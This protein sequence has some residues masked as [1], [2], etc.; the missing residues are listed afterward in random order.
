MKM[1][2][3]EL[4][5]SIQL[6]IAM[7]IDISIPHTFY[8]NSFTYHTETYTTTPR[9]NTNGQSSLFHLYLLISSPVLSIPWAFGGSRVDIFWCWAAHPVA[10][11]CAGGGQGWPWKGGWHAGRQENCREELRIPRDFHRR[12]CSVK[13]LGHHAGYFKLAHTHAA[14]WSALFIVYLLQWNFFFFIW[15]NYFLIVVDKQPNDWN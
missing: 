11:P 14:R 1:A 15:C 10:Q 13:D 3:H 7:Y 2:V 12:A 9:N 5:I 8:I 4:D 6:R